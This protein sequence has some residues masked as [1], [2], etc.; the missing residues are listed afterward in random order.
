MERIQ[1]VVYDISVQYVFAS[2]R[3]KYVEQEFSLYF[4]GESDDI[5]LHAVERYIEDPHHSRSASINKQIHISAFK[6]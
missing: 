5:L 6:G 3:K 4:V 2:F 1:L